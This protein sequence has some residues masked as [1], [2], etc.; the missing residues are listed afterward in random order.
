MNTLYQDKESTAGATQAAVRKYLA[1]GIAPIPIPRGSKNPGR[2]NWQAERW[3][4]DDIPRAWNNGQNVGLL[5]GEPSDWLV[6]VDLDHH[7]ATK[8]AGRFL[9]PTRTSGRDGSP[10]SHWWYYAQGTETKT[11]RD[12]DHRKRLIELRSTGSQTV[13]APSVHP[14]KGDR[15]VWNQQSGLDFAQSDKDDLLYRVRKLSTAVLIAK[16]LPSLRDKRTDEGGGRHDYAMALVGFLF[17]SLHLSDEDAVAILKG[18]W[19]T[20]DWPNEQKRRQAHRDLEGIVRDT[21]ERIGTNQPF[22]G[23]PTLEEMVPRMPRTLGKY[24]DSEGNFANSANSANDNKGG[25]KPTP[26]TH[27]EL[28]DRLL[29]NNPDL[30]FGLGEWQRYGGGIWTPVPESEVKGLTASVLEDAKPEGTKPTLSAVN[31]V[32]ALAQF[33]AFV[34]DELWDADPD[35]LICANGALHI[36]SGELGPYAK[37]HYA[38]S[39][40]PYSYDPEAAAPRW[41]FLLNSSVC[42]VQGFLQEFAG[43]ALTTGTDLETAVWLYGPPGS[44]KSTFLLGLETMLGARAGTLGLADI[45]RTH[46]ALAGIA[47]KTLLTAAEQ[48][49]AFLRS[50]HIINQLISGEKL[51]VE[52]KYRDGYDLIP[53]AKL[54]W[55]M[56]ELPRVGDANSGIFRRVKVVAFP[57]IAPED[58]HPE[59]KAGIASEGPGILNWALEG[60]RR[61]R[62]RGRF[63]VPEAIQAATDSFQESNDVAAMFVEERC[64]TT[65]PDA[66]EGSGTLYGEYK[67][68]CEDNGHRPLSSTRMAEE[69]KRLGFERYKAKG[70]TRYRGVRLGLPDA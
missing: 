20:T 33:R 59:I 54:A 60:L 34:R 45:E 66:S 42:V 1:R 2:D 69:W 14:D 15:Y 23:G 31:S 40:V 46:F 65:N 37:E 70:N 19:D 18:A 64:D 7:L 9:E 8:I 22:F 58:R 21:A 63:E 67:F 52:Q 10:D 11:F 12:L 50:T 56:N 27:D 43:Y 48:P 4:L 62:Q 53:R 17:N 68:W 39:A 41:Q 26:P 5:L 16:Y 61:L 6:D 49:S 13:V 36:P 32:A 29:A 38:T 25:E 35:I 55:A 3:G 51:R 47:G 24:W 28:R 57:P 44:G 30:V